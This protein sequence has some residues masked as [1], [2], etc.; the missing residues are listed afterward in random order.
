M[1]YNR[2]GPE[3]E[4]K[5]FVCSEVNLFTFLCSVSYRSPGRS[6]LMTVGREMKNYPSQSVLPMNQLVGFQNQSQ[7]K[8]IHQKGLVYDSLLKSI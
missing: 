2:K 5:S 3:C 1:L 4:T 8:E 6:S 7:L